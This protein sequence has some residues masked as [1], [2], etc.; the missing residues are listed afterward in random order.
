MTYQEI[1]LKNEQNINAIMESQ[2]VFWAFSNEQ[3]EKGKQS[4]NITD[5]K[6]LTSIGMGGF[7]PKANADNLFI[8]LEEENKRY[9]QE[10]KE[11]KEAKEKAIAYELSNHE[12]YY[13][14]DISPVIEL[15]AGL[16]TKDDIK[17]VFNKLNKENQN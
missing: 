3:L 11:A 14:G 13:T 7:L 12:C 8:L 10:L 5:N 16:Y 2:K 17:Q 6:E 9:K 1:K 15:F 4:I